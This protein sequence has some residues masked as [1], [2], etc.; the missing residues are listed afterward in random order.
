MDASPIMT[1]LAEAVNES[2]LTVGEIARLSGVSV[3]TIRRVQHRR[4]AI[5][6]SVAWNLAFAISPEKPH[7]V[8]SSDKTLTHSPVSR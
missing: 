2:A 4:G 8:F 6:T 5:T 1:R 7:S 3:T